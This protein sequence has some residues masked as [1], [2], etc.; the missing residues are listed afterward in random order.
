[1]FWADVY[2]LLDEVNV[3]GTARWSPWASISKS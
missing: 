1:M 3:P 2:A